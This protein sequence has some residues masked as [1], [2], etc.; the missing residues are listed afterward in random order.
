[1]SSR[2]ALMRP[3]KITTATG[4]RT[5]VPGCSASNSS[6]ASANAVTSAVISTG[7]SRSS[8]PRTIILWPKSSPSM[9]IRFT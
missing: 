5:S 3:E 7:A 8:E 6:G 1:M 4:C 9:R 2:V